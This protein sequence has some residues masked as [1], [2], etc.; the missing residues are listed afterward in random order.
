MIISTGKK[1]D[2]TM[3]CFAGFTL[4]ELLVVIAIIA[5]L[6]A[7]LLPA[8]SKAKQKAQSMRCMNNEHQ[9]ALA[10]IMYANDN[11]DQL[12][13]NGGLGRNGGGNTTGDPR[14]DP[15]WGAGGNRCGWCPGS[16]QIASEVTPG[17]AYPEGDK[18]A[19]WI[20]AGLLW[21]SINNLDVYRCPADNTT[22]PRGNSPTAG[23]GP[24]LRTYSMNCC[25]NPIDSAG[26][27]TAQWVGVTGGPWCVYRNLTSFQRPG[28]SSTFVFIEESHITIDDGFFANDPGNAFMWLNLPAVLH[29]SASNLS[30]AD[31]HAQSRKWTDGRMINAAWSTPT[32]ANLGASPFNPDLPWLLSVTTAPSQ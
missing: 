10:W 6:A 2:F 17:S 14:Q 16:L 21:P 23:P 15:E 5:I 24:A 13:P 31:G 26:F 29:R 9:L 32:P 19:W 30:F 28:P 11:R 1:R 27:A 3:A 20:Q 4:I 22:V 25:V 8:L 18:Y 7:L 12:T